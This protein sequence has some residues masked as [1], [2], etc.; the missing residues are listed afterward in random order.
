MAEPTPKSQCPAL[1]L[2]R[3]LRQGCNEHDQQCELSVLRSEQDALSF[4][5]DSDTPRRTEG[6]WR[7]VQSAD[8][9]E[10]YLQQRDGCA[11]AAVDKRE[12]VEHTR[13]LVLLHLVSSSQQHSMGYNND[14]L[15]TSSSHGC[16]SG[17]GGRRY[18]T[19]L[20][21]LSASALHVH[22]H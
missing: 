4:R 3:Q 12:P 17:R 13:E 10:T 5:T 14:P 19:L 15:L 6:G 1:T 22:V 7:G 8:S 11:A 20:V 9:G 18:T 21:R 2:N 16:I